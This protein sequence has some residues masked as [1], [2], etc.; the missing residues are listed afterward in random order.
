MKSC[1]DQ[2][3]DVL[4]CNAACIHVMPMK[5]RISCLRHCHPVP[6]TSVI[7]ACLGLLVRALMGS[8]PPGSVDG[9]HFRQA[10][11]QLRVP[12]L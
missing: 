1:V 4:L 12:A 11:A 3:V 8:L 6:L 9:R 5:L 10:A 2:L 7:I